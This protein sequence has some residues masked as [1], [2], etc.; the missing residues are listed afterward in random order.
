[1]F[2]AGIPS[3]LSLFMARWYSCCTRNGDFLFLYLKLKLL[4][5]ADFIS[6]ITLITSSMIDKSSYEIKD[7][8]SHITLSSYFRVPIIQ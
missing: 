3:Y 4:F 8:S 5:V 6:I 2:P 7:Y 1:M